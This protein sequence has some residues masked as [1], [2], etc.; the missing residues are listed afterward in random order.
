MVEDTS[1]IGAASSVSV[2][3]VSFA[4]ST[5]CFLG[6]MTPKSYQSSGNSHF[7][8]QTQHS[9]RGIQPYPFGKQQDL[10]KLC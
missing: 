1:S 4:G 10:R 3:S 2:S 8:S 6:S 9:L 7:H 5:S